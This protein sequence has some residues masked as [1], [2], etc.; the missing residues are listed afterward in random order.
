MLLCE[1]YSVLYDKDQ[2]EILGSMNLQINQHARLQIGAEIF[3][4][5]I[6]GRH[7]KNSTIL[8]K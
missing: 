4:S 1:W 5:M 6:T 3:G 7:E 2:E 8:A